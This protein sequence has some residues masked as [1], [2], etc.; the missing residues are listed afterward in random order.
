MKPKPAVR[1]NYPRD[2]YGLGLVKQPYDP[3]RC[4]HEVVDAVWSTQCSRPS[5][6]GD[7][8]LF[9]RQHAKRYPAPE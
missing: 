4:A 6:H 9:C 7:Q 5:G 3:T 2:A 8:A 1:H